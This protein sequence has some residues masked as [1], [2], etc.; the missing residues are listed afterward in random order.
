VRE[1]NLYRGVNVGPARPAPPPALPEIAL[2]SL[3]LALTHSP[4][5]AITEVFEDEKSCTKAQLSL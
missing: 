3:P 4:G 1:L 2:T 5:V